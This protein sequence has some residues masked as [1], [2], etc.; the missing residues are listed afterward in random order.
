[1]G[2]TKLTKPKMGNPK[3]TN[4]K[5]DLAK[6]R[7]RPISPINKST[8]NFLPFFVRQS[9]RGRHRSASR[10]SSDFKEA[11]FFLIFEFNNFVYVDIIF[12]KVDL[13]AQL[14]NSALIAAQVVLATKQLRLD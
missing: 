11:I 3:L 8:F 4:P 1:M 2:K 14:G 7:K 12:E 9:L 5:P 10:F 13:V 6:C